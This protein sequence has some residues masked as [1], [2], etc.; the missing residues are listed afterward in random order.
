MLPEVATLLEQGVNLPNA[1][2]FY[3]VLGPA[4]LPPEVLLKLNDSLVKALKSPLLQS[5][6]TDMGFDVVASSSDEYGKKIRA[7]IELWSKI[8]K[9]NQIKLE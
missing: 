7:E 6:L 9:E 8:V 2:P 1:A 5:K 3:G 4:G